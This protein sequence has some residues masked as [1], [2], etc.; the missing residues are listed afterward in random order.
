M[1]RP[2]GPV[3]IR[4]RMEARFENRFKTLLNHHLGNAVG[5]HRRYIPAKTRAFIDFLKEDFRINEYEARWESL[6]RREPSRM[7]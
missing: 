7:G 5:Q 6:L 2:V 3:S 4:I 1:G